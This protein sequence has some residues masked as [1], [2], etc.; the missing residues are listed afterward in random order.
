[1]QTATTFALALLRVTGMIQIILGVLFWTGNAQAL[2]PIHMRIGF[3]LVFALWTLALLAARAGINPGLVALTLVWGVL[4][5]TLGLTQARLLTGE[6][7]WVIQVLHLLL[8]LSAMGQGEGLATR[9]ESSAGI[10]GR[11]RARGPA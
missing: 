4:V 2:I 9:I 10:H 6:G 8:G 1:M 11:D 7:H 3:V 5:P